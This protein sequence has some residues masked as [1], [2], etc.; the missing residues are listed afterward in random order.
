MKTK[1]TNAAKLKQLFLMGLLLTGLAASSQNNSSNDLLTDIVS[2]DEGKYKFQ[3]FR[4]ITSGDKSIQLKMYSECSQSVISRDQFLFYSISLLFKMI[5]EITPE[6]SY[7][8][9]ID[10]LIGN[11]DA[12]INLYMTKNGLQVE[13]KT[14]EG[15]KRTTSKWEEL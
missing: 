15:V 7:S 14:S 1:K 6:G 4:L 9:D 3:V 2:V 10:E 5:D 8:R 13:V 12:E 11:P